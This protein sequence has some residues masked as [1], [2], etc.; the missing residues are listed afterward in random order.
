VN[1]NV[2]FNI[3]LSKNIVHSLVKIKRTL[4]IKMHGTTV[5]NRFHVSVAADTRARCVYNTAAQ[6]L[7]MFR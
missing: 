2:D 3:L 1:F 7:Y 4:I 6:H 5:K